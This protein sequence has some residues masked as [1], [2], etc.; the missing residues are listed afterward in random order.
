MSIYRPPSVRNFKSFIGELTAEAAAVHISLLESQK[1]EDKNEKYWSEK[2]VEAEIKLEGIKTDRII[3]SQNRLSIVSIY[4]GFDLY[5]EEIESECKQFGFQWI[6]LEKTPLLEILEKNFTKTPLNKTYF[7]YES[8]AA[9][10]FRLL[11]NSI[12]HPSA[13]SKQKAIECYKSKKKSLEY[14]QKKYQMI[15]APNE[16]NSISF[17]D[18]KFWCQFLLDFTE[19]IAELLEPTEK[20]IYNSLPLDRWRKYGKDHKKRKEVAKKYLRSQYSYNVDKADKI[21]ENFYDLLA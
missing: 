4:S 18:I 13:E 10:Y 19:E 12:A 21:I 17:H 20:M 16:P 11:R 14:L 1:C 9:D 7:R 15:S 6:K 3:N 5:L 8:D 2:A